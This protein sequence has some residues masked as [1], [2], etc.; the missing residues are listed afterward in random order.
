MA[1]PNYWV[2]TT[3]VRWFSPLVLVDRQWGRPP[4]CAGLPAPPPPALPERAGQRP[5][6][7]QRSAPLVAVRSICRSSCLGLS[8]LLLPAVTLYA[9]TA[10]SVEPL[11]RDYFK[12]PTQA[13]RAGLVK[14][15][16]QHPNDSDGALALLAVAQSD[17]DAKR[18]AE[19]IGELKALDKRLPK[20]SDYVAFLNA[21]AQ[22]N[23]KQDD[24]AAK[25]A[26]PAWT[27]PVKSPLA[28]RAAM[29]AAKAL[30]RAEKP[31]E[32]LD[33]LKRTYADL[34]QPAGDE[35]LAETFEA[36]ADR[37]SAAN[38]YQRVY[39][40]YPSSKEAADAASGMARMRTALGESYPPV[41]PAASFA[42]AQKLLDSGSPRLA[43]QEFEALA[44]KLGG[45]DRDTA[46]VRAG[47]AM[48]QS[49]D[50]AAALRYLK[51][52]NVPAGEADA[53]RHSWIITASRQAEAPGEITNSVAEL[54]KRYPASKWRLE[55]LVAAGFYYF[56]KGQPD[57]YAPLYQQCA[58]SFSGDPQAATCHWRYT[59]AS[60]IR[61]KAESVEMLREHVTRYPAD[62]NVPACLY[63]L[64]RVAESR[65]DWAGARTFYEEVNQA[66]PNFYYS[67]LSRNRLK[68]SRIAGASTANSKVS[69]FLASVKFPVRRRVEDFT[70]TAAT[71]VRLE[72]AGLLFNA[73]LDAFA[74]GELRFGG[75][76][77]AQG[78]L[79]AM[80][81]AAS[82]TRRGMPDQGI[83]WVKAMAPGYLM[84]P[85]ES[86]PR[87]FWRY[88]YPLPYRDILEKY[89]K[90]HGLDP[91]ITAG[92]IRQESEFDAR[93]IS[94]SNAYGLMQILPSTGRELGMRLGVQRVATSDLFNPN[95]NV[96]LGTFYVKHLLDNFGNELER[97]LASYNAGMGR[98]K[99]W[100]TGAP[101]YREPAEWVE[102]IPFTETRGYVQSVMRNADFYRRL[103]ANAPYEATPVAY[104]PPPPAPASVKAKGKAATT[105]KRKHVASS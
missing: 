28:A 79:I 99:Q 22:F 9:Q 50:Y 32:A 91:F 11:V 96:R 13:G 88:A 65:N 49:R 45:A 40:Q 25:A 101:Q 37:A 90:E 29:L 10:A 54:S 14:F 93:V 55:G 71:R 20:I 47:A 27:S 6:A 87:D 69:E 61:G 36:A 30:T 51:A 57:R 70:P 41:M 53:E 46:S 31:R 89:S 86:A 39:Y 67:L 5:A 8:L 78:H 60:Y 80:E 104:K 16:Q 43:R 3:R 75:K 82:A 52:L 84:Y 1:I 12:N 18:E 100:L 48:V 81:L 62:E 38:Y 23:L 92:L 15:A 77:D 73:G 21:T 102:T 26:A 68:D 44:P 4:A 63:F 74:E 66:Y 59:L 83:R 97:S 24:A 56:L 7:D 34:P 94:H 103:Y 35:L 17:I 76:T 98:V 2:P 58:D 64:G 72:R 105:A 85:L 19:A 33:V 42:R 95:V